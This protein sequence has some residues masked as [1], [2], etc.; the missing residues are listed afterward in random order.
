MPRIIHTL[1]DWRLDRRENPDVAPA[2]TFE[3]TVP[4][5][6]QLDYAAAKGLP[7]HAQ[8][9]N[10]KRYDGLE[11]SWWV[12]HTTLPRASPATDQRR[13]LCVQGVDY[14]YDLIIDGETVLTHEGM[15][16]GVELD[17]THLSPKDH[18][19][20]IRVHPA[21][22]RPDAPKD[23]A[24]ADTSTKPAAS[25]GWDWHPRLITLGVWQPITIE[26][27]P[28]VHI[29]HARATVGLSED[30]T[31]ATIGC[32]IELSTAGD[33]TCVWEIVSPDGKVV[34][35]ETSGAL[36]FAPVTIEKPQLWWPHDHG[37]PAMY[38]ARFSLV[39]GDGSVVDEVSHRFGIR[40]IELV[41]APGQL[42][43]PELFPKS[44]SHPP[45]TLR[46]NG[47]DVFAKGSNWVNPDVH[48][49]TMTESRY[50]D[51]LTLARD[52]N[53]NIL[54]VWGGGLACHEWF[55]DLCDELGLMV[56]QEFPLACN[57]YDHR[58]RPEYLCVLEQEAKAI[59]QRLRRH[60]SLALWCGGNEL[61]N[62]WSG[63]TDQSLALRLLNKLCYDLDPQTPFLPT[64]PV[65]G[66]A[67][68][69][70]IFFDPKQGEVYQ[71]MN[72]SRNT[73]YTEFG[74]P[75]ASP[76][77]YLKTF[78]P[79]DQLFPPKPGGAWEDHHAFGVWQKESWLHMDV[80]EK[81]FGDS[82]SLEELVARSEWLQC[83]GYKAIFEEARRQKPRCS[84]ALNWCFNEPWPTA[85]NNSLVNYPSH[86]KP[87][88]HAVRDAC[89]PL[90][91]SARLSKFAWREGEAF[92]PQLWL[93]NDSPNA[94]PPGTITATLVL[95]DDRHPLLRW[96]HH[97][98]PANTHLAGPTLHAVLPHADAE[99]MTLELRYAGAR[100]GEG[101][102]VSRYRLRYHPIASTRKP[103]SR[104]LNQ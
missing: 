14:A 97:G 47:R 20:R 73:A 57:N 44:R 16:S 60:P 66:M 101:E 54:R 37:T 83:E 29:K 82:R 35:R 89:R 45:I 43:E 17:I 50:R 33:V 80:I 24:Q 6:V 31:R 86:P 71:I 81:Y 49:G 40:R 78:I 3:A 9:S 91:P 84:M 32:D 36:D 51:L 88:Y 65:D 90:M 85:A 12:Y 22:K 34:S 21:P 87:A 10:F 59:I 8:A 28:L 46:V 13:V 39:A 38:T 15:F 94:L 74:C 55:F 23:R 5:A 96:D 92:D 27:R 70:Y 4:G 52:A 93:L 102:C 98:T 72:G 76:V 67:H 62:S 48:P 69:H 61:F 25:Y 64:S 99:E 56:W 104:V 75:G 58:K 77:E 2:E 79:A 11:D 26:T 7:D 68:G 53:F 95:G 30:C 63:M 103:E 1:T 19:L 18:S 42:Q 100:D 41:M